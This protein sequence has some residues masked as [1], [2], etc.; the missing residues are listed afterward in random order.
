MGKKV[1]KKGRNS[2]KEKRVVTPSPK[3]GSQQYNASVETVGDGVSV[4][5]GRN[6]CVHLDRGVDLSKVSKKIGSSEPIKCEDCRE[7]VVDRKG[8]RAKGK[9][10]K[11]KGGGPGD[12]KS[13]SRAIWVC[14]ECGHFVCGGIGLPTST[15]SHAVRHARLTRHPLAIQFEN[16]NLRW[17]FPC[18]TLIPVEK[19]EENGEQVDILSDIVK[20]IKGRSAVAAPV[21]VED[22]WFGSGSI[23]SEMKPGNTTSGALDGRDGYTV[24][25][26]VNLG[27][28][29]FFN[30]VMQNL[31]SM[32]RLRDYFVKLDGSVGPLTTALKKL[33]FE[34]ISEG[35][36]R[37][38]INPKS[39]FGSVCAKAPQFRG[40]Q[41]HDS[42]E[43][44]LFL[45]DGL[46][47]EELSMKKQISSS[48]DDGNSPNEGPTFV[49]YL[50]GGQTSSTVCCLE[51]GHSSTVWE[52]FLDLSLPVPT[53][54]P[55][56]KKAQL[57][58][59]TRKMK[60]PPKRGGR[61]RSKFNKDTD[62]TST[63]IVSKPSVSCGSSCQEQSNATVEEKVTTCSGDSTFLGSAGPVIVD[64]NKG[65]VSQNILTAELSETRLHSENLMEKTKVSFDDLTWMDYLEPE[66][67]LP[68]QDVAP[69]NDDVLVTQGF[70]E[71]DTPHNNVSSESN[72]DSTSQVYL[73]PNLKSE[74][75]P[76]SSGK[77]MLPEQ[78]QDSEVL[79]LPYKEETSTSVEVMRV[80]GEASSSFVGCKQDSLDFDGFGHLF[81]EPEVVEGPTA[82][83]LPGANDFQE[84]E[85]TETGF[86]AGNSSDSEPDVV[87]NTDSPVS[88][89]SCLAYFVKPELL[90][91]EH[92]WQC[93]NCSKNASKQKIKL[94][95]NKLKLKSSIQN[96]QG[97][98]IAYNDSLS[99]NKDLSCPSE[100][101]DLGNGNIKSGVV[102]DTSSESFVSHYGDVN[103]STQ[104][105]AKLETSQ[106]DKL[107]PVVPVVP[108]SEG[109]N[110]K[111]ACLES[112]HSSCCYRTCSE[113]SFSDQSN[114]IYTI[115]EPSRS[116]GC[117]PR[118]PQLSVEIC[119]SGESEEVEMDSETVKVKRDATKRILINKAPPILT[120]H[121]KRFS[122]DARG[123]LSKLNG[124]V[125]F[126]D[127]IDLQPYMDHR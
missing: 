59:R 81:D 13:D 42:H 70:K 46:S 49:D 9:H 126:R 10:G 123:R 52:P 92:A 76:E 37:N 127:T 101:R 98:D 25:G 4:A 88:V 29:C 71:K 14:L 120:I 111:D 110:G 63:Q 47:T 32:D 57:A 80:E 96:N 39:F 53:K 75:S 19:S 21:D 54:K 119:E 45:L 24:R 18:N 65:P 112:P 34:T 97:K 109:E 64:D 91:N 124:H 44:L 69:Q 102:L 3:I 51:C 33:F 108:Q 84:N 27:N 86:I 12:L 115:N 121:L 41:Q 85:V 2:H 61:V 116:I 58:S 90:S 100:V 31:L 73:Q 28:T 35:G 68:D 40:Y 94:R 7:G 82:K 6:L 89:E 104:N 22:V 79:L 122:Q 125:D 95:K 107:K 26:L 20:L 114:E 16:P 67:I 77:D 60:L 17:C 50:F 118:D 8:N 105:K 5:K 78:V 117:K 56:S 99:L 38:A 30:S 106:A 83:N 103:D 15:Q 1:K 43:L 62:A 113:A 48:Q 74:S 11:R 87:D 55:V 93:E 72:F 23:M 36:L 66:T